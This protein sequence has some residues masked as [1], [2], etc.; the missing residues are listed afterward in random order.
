MPR[1]ITIELDDEVYE[2]LMRMAAQVRRTPQEVVAELV[3]YAI[4]QLESQQDPGSTPPSRRLD[5]G[6][7]GRK[8]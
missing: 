6:G 2:P 8:P 7:Y 3:A 5:D 4:R 1:L